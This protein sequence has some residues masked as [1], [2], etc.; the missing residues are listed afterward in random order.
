[1]YTNC[2][3]AVITFIV[4]ISIETHLKICYNLLDIY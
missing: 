3:S 4:Y 1:M 2:R